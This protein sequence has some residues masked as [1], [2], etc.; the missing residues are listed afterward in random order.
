MLAAAKS[1]VVKLL[2]VACHA[3][4]AGVT[5]NKCHNAASCRIAC[6]DTIVCTLTLNLG[7]CE[8]L[9]DLGHSI[10]MTAVQQRVKHLHG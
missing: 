6:H 5:H 2:Q 10:L 8:I 3:C 4:G 1:K 7:S 9:T